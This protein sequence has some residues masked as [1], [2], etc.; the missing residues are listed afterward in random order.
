M[1]HNTLNAFIIVTIIWRENFFVVA[2]GAD[3]AAFFH[4]FSFKAGYD[5]VFCD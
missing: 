1:P 5:R 2:V 4:R 3:A